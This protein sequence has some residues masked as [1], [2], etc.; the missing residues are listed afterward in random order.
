M[1]IS[2]VNNQMALNL[3]NIRS[4]IHKFKINDI[5]Y[6]YHTEDCNFHTSD[7]RSIPPA[8]LYANLMGLKNIQFEEVI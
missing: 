1:E 3:A 4:S 6:Q 7:G 2:Y 5:T 8:S